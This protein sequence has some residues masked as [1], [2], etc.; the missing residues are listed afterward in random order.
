MNY[1]IKI[2]LEPSIAGLVTPFSIDV[3]ALMNNWDVQRSF[4]LA[5]KTFDEAH[6]HELK[7]G[8]TESRWMDFRVR[9]GVTGAG[10]LQPCRY[11][12]ATQ[13]L[14]LTDDGE[15]EDSSVDRQGTEMFFTWG[16]ASASQLSVLAE[17]QHYG[18]TADD[19]SVSP[20]SA[21]Y[22]GVNSDDLSN[23]ERLNVGNDGN[24]PPYSQFSHADYL[25]K[26][27]TIRYQPGADGLQRL[28][29]G[30]FDAPCGLFVMKH[31][32]AGNLS[33][34]S[35]MF[36]AKAGDYKGVDAKAMSN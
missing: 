26:V 32:F 23:I 20:S 33:N 28:S 2:D 10:R 21:P 30:F 35:V 29:T 8:N 17:W 34:G 22:D 14:I 6:A 19:P 24:K 36:T 7:A 9:D 4:A 13:A 27:A 16:G 12:Q 15:H 1:Q 5:K 31:N 18:R 11:D 25:V 3:Y